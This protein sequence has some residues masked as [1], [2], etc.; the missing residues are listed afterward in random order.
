MTVF[1]LLLSLQREN[2]LST[3]SNKKD[4]SYLSNIWFSDPT[5]AIS[6]LGPSD[7]VDRKEGQ[8]ARCG[9]VADR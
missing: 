2:K 7:A 3:E 4:A 1:F 6:G 9:F 5:K 8:L